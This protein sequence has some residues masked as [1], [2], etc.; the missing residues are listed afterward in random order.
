MEIMRAVERADALCPNHYTVEEKL[1]WCD[2]VTADIRRNIIKVYDMIET[3]I[4]GT[5]EVI[6]P[7]DV[8]FERVELAFVNGKRMEKQ[9]FRSFAR[10]FSRRNNF[11]L[12]QKIKVVFLKMPEP[13]RT[14]EIKGEFNT[15][16]CIIEIDTA[17]FTEGDRIEIVKLESLSD[18]PDW[19]KSRLAYVI[20][21]QPDK[22]ILDK[23]VAAAQS[24]VKL[25]IKRVVDEVTAVDE[26]PYDGMYVEYILA[27]MA[28]YQ[29]DYVAYNA[30]MAQYN[31]LYEM[32]RREYK[33]RSPLS[34]QSN[35]RNYAVI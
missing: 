31:I 35:F 21:V 33:T 30:H 32:L 23:D 17:P 15:G 11:G 34:N 28:F 10:N 12:S 25:A 19:A 4:D 20:E 18:E 22:I 1:E 9:D 16:D 24:G 8:A 3:Q 5:G 7:D 27:K 26:A 13:I 14:T 29:H 6:L 2:E